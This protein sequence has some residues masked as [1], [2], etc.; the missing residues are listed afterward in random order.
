MAESD[1][2]RPLPPS[3]PHTPLP[4][5]PPPLFNSQ[6][7]TLFS[8]L[9]FDF[10]YALDSDYNNFLSSSSLPFLITDLNDSNIIYRN[11]THGLPTP[12][13]PPLPPPPTNWNYSFS[14]FDSTDVDTFQEEDQY[15]LD[16]DLVENLLICDRLMTQELT[17]SEETS[18]CTICQD[19]LK[20][21]QVVKRMPC[22]HIFHSR[23][24]LTWLESNHTCPVYRYQL[25][26]D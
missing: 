14:Y 24:L 8:S 25:P 2:L 13:P 5:P 3:S 9:E 18:I 11:T 12:L 26:W 21:N 19:D 22:K 7:A 6:T 10:P 1:D 15:L 4:S 16:A 20:L 17:N 23:C